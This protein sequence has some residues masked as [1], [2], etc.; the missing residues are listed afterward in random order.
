MSF[1]DDVVSAGSSVIKGMSG[2]GILPTL[3]RTA[4]IGFAMAAITK[5][6]TKDNA[7]PAAAD[8]GRTD[9]EARVQQSP[10]TQ[11]SIPVVYGSAFLGATVT[12]AALVN[13][14]KTMY[15]A[16]TIC[17][18]TG[19]LLSTGAPSE[20]T[21]SEV[22]WE[23]AK[24]NFQADGIT[25][26]SITD[27]SG[28]TSTDF[29]GLVKIYCFAGN[30]QLPVVP[31]GYSNGNLSA[32]YGVMPTWSSNHQMNDLVFAIVRVDYNREKNLTGLGT[33]GFKITNSM[34][35]PGDCINDYMTNTRYG[36]GIPTSEIYSV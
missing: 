25:V 14:N 5:S 34:T 16:M 3:A 27:E 4:A 18:R 24:I 10:D 32:A 33:M 9:T 15:F 29:A 35:Q 31:T 11:S 19:T 22:Y 30:S 8:S 6:M 20:F 23:G 28:T 21:F 26:A 1:I 12:D 13:D 2:P 36:A 17:E 7:T